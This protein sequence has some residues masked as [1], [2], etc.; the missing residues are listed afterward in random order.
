[1]S[2]PVTVVDA[3]SAST[4]SRC[5]TRSSCR[6]SATSRCS[7]SPVLRTGVPGHQQG[8]VAQRERSVRIEP[9]GVRGDDGPLPDR[10]L[11]PG[12]PDLTGI[13][14]TDSLVADLTAAGCTI[15]D[16]LA[17][18]ASFSCAYSLVAVRGTTT[19]TATADSAET[20]RRSTTARP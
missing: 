9:D 3:A 8:G 15:P 5:G 7:S 10:G 6:A 11:Q 17:A 16:T 18:H 2:V 12:D 14:L 20:T 13:T 4:P 1:M 19:N